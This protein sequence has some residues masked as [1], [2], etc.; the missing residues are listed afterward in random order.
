MEVKQEVD[1]NII[2]KTE[3]H[4][5][6][7]ENSLLDIYKIEIKEEPKIENTDGTFDHLDLKEYP[8]KT[9][10]DEDKFMP[11]EEKT[12]KTAQSLVEISPVGDRHFELASN[13][14]NLSDS[15]SDNFN[16]DENSTFSSS[17]CSSCSSSNNTTS[18]SGE[19]NEIKENI[20]SEGT[21]RKKKNINAWKK[22]IRKQ[23][24]LKGE[25]YVCSRSIERPARPMLPS[26]CSGKANHKCDTF[27]N[28][29]NRRKIYNE[30]RQMI[31]VDDQRVFLN[32]HID[33]QKK[34]RM[35]RNI[36]NSRRTFTMNYSFTVNEE[37]RQVCRAFFMATLNVTDAFMRGA[38]A[39]LSSSGIVENENRGKHVPHNKLK[40]DDELLIREHILSFPAVE[41]HY[42]RAS[43]TKRYLDS[44]LNV[45]IM[46][47]LYKLKCSELNVHPVSYEKYRRVL[48]T[49]NLGF[50]KPKKGPV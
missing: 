20:L 21:K 46:H 6:D 19:Q 30:F 38:V 14:S 50:H 40:D 10:I 32:S 26:P 44:S 17:S 23:K 43:S 28:E 42:C 22:N 45:S 35:T 47:K 37:K 9:E 33:K 34:K 48:R 11:V 4:N 7:V 27:I 16:P 39:K 3:I 41:F 5:N 2:C 12:N 8:I 15:S 36:E 1:E 31:S 49:Y 18:E 25:S 13:K 29:E 24:R